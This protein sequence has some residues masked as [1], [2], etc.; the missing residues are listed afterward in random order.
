M[1]K[2]L[3]S[4]FTALLLSCNVWAQ[5]SKVSKYVVVHSELESAS[6]VKLQIKTF[7]KSKKLVDTEVQCAA[8][9]AILFDG[10][11]DTQYRKPML[12]DGEKTLTEMHPVYF[13][14]LFGERFS[15]FILD[16]T[17]LSKFKDSDKDNST[18]YEVKVKILQL[19]RDLE[20]NNIKKQI[21]L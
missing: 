16:Y 15:D 14:K 1:Y 12:T 19:R 11:P 8:I 9:R 13:N 21:G 20:K 4:I 6:V 18:L 17:M 3:F 2:A 10:I 5:D 7:C